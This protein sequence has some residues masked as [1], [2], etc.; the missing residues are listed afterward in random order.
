MYHLAMR[1]DPSLMGKSKCETAGSQCCRNDGC[2]HESGVRLDPGCKAVSSD[3]DSYQINSDIA[4]I[5]KTRQKL[6]L[7]SMYRSSW[8][9]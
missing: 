3:I 2:L 9:E 8:G 4:I 5:Q 7:N 6:V 1:V